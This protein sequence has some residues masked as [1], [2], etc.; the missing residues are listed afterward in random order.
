MTAIR[1]YDDRTI[2]VSAS[3]DRVWLGARRAV[4]K[5]PAPE[6]WFTGARNPDYENQL[7]SVDRLLCDRRGV[8]V[9]FGPPALAAL[10]VAQLEKYAA[11][12]RTVTDAD[13][14]IYVVRR[15]KGAVQ[16]C[17]PT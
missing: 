10:G 5:M 7:A 13:G 3:P 12:E 6:V 2:V 11:L 9:S 17:R 8:V 15:V 1:A 14:S 16:P 4:V